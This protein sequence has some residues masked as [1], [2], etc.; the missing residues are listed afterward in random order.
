[1]IYMTMLTN[2]EVLAK[3]AK[4]T[5]GNLE[6]IPGDDKTLAEVSAFLKCDK[7][8]SIIFSIVFV[9]SF[10]EEM[11]GI[12]DVSD[13]L[14]CS[15]IKLAGYLKTMEQLNKK[16]L[17]RLD[18]IRYGNRR[19]MA[20]QGFNYY[21]PKEIVNA[22]LDERME[23]QPKLEFDT[24]SLLDHINTLVE[25]RN[26][27]ELSFDGLMEDVEQA[28]VNNGNLLF[29]QRIRH[30]KLPDKNLA[31]LLYVC[32]ET[33]N[34]T[35]EIDLP[36]A[37][38]KLFDQN[39][40]RFNLRR[41]IIQGKS[42]LIQKDL[43][44]V[45][46]GMF[47]N[48]KQILLSDHA[49]ELLF[50]KDKQLVLL[51]R[52]KRNLIGPAD[53]AEEKLFF[54]KKVNQEL[55]FLF[56]SLTEENF[57]KLRKR[58]KEKNL[59]EGLTMLFHG[60]PGTG[61]TACAYQIAKSTGRSIIPVDISKSKSMWYGES[62]KL[63]KDIFDDYRKLLKDSDREPILL[64]NE[65]DGILSKRKELNDSPI[66]QTENAM[67]NILLDELEKFRGILIA[68]TN[69]TQNL[70]FAFERRFLYKILF[71]LPDAGIRRK[72]LQN[73]FTFLGEGEAEEIAAS[74]S[75]SGGNINNISKKLLMMEVLHH[76]KP[77]FQ[78]LKKLCSDEIW[79]KGHINAV[80]FRKYS[81]N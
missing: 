5:K 61:K 72:I 37:C 33:I 45:Q 54:N 48:D 21:V 58:L 35:E 65:S 76:K 43:L 59:K 60:P 7:S 10:K 46:P 78:V 68:T 66:S 51:N 31:L 19:N 32:S 11:V 27:E 34:G 1:M 56:D 16:R 39:S 24:F 41:E 77:G 9:I 42:E 6:N 74:F 30:L 63:I 23:H 50:D 70:D 28:L 17:I 3:K 14:N 22:I 25:E 79:K 47:R 62:E 38:E 36:D 69:L 15:N 75:L 52:E 18:T 81:S 44:K 40:W 71:D 13:Y 55:R 64:F 20:I 29:V 26:D 80:G 12:D 53:I 73:F 2:I 4:K 57:R 8:Q 67:Q 49:L